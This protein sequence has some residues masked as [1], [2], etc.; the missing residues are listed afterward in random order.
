[1]TSIFSLSVRPCS[2]KSQFVALRSPSISASGS[3]R[4]RAAAPPAVSVS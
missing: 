4:M 2:S 1:V 3:S